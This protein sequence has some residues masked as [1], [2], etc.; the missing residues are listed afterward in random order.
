MIKKN[1]IQTKKSRKTYQ[2]SEKR[3]KITK[4]V[5]KSRKKY[6]NRRKREEN[7]KNLQKV[8]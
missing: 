5:P 1:N 3:T 4:D 6:Q 8:R 7:R 2:N